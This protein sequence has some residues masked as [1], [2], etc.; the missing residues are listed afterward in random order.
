MKKVT[1][2]SLVGLGMV[3]SLTAMSA[4]ANTKEE[5]SKRV[6]T[7]NVAYCSELEMEYRVQGQTREEYLLKCVNE[8]LERDGHSKIRALSWH[9]H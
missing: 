4:N 5:V 9:H 3:S 6:I 7:D 1:L 8:Q 2:A